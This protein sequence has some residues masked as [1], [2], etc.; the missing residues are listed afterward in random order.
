MTPRAQDVLEVF[1]L[2]CV[3]VAEHALHEDLGKADDRVQRCAELVRHVGEEVGFV[4][5]RALE[6]RDRVPEFP[7][8]LGHLLLET[9]VGITQPCRHLVERFGELLELVARPNVD[10]L[11]PGARTNLRRGGMECLDGTD[12]STSEEDAQ[13]QRGDERDQEE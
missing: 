11:V 7:R 12:H 1:L 13:Q 4:P 8:P 9:V 6:L 2:F 3:D 10:P 5:A